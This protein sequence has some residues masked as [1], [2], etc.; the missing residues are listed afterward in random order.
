MLSEAISFC[1][2]IVGI[3]IEVEVMVVEEYRRCCCGRRHGNMWRVIHVRCDHWGLP[4]SVS[5]HVSNQGYG[6]IAV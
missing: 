2:G 4:F 3:D 1:I 6:F 5:I